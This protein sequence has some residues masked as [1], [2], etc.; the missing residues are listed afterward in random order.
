MS[1][2]V[3]PNAL[4][5]SWHLIRSRVLN[6]IIISDNNGMTQVYQDYTIHTKSQGQSM[7]KA[8]F[9]PTN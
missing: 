2:I 1:I 5:V 6:P 4:K 8:G 7:G 9:N 3:I